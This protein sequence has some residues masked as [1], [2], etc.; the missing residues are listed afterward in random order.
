[1]GITERR[2]RE[3]L[4]R[5]NDILD[6]AEKIF[7]SEGIDKA[8]MDDVA[9]EAEL[10]KGT[11]Y[12]Y[13]KS[14]QEL[15]LGINLRGLEIL[16]T[17]LLKKNIKN[18]SGLKKLSQMALAYKDFADEYP[19]YFKAIIHFEKV[20][21]DAGVEQDLISIAR[22]AGLEVLEITTAAIREGINDNS[23]KVVQDPRV[24]SFLLWGQ[25][26][27]V[28][29]MIS[30]LGHQSKDTIGFDPNILF[31]NFIQMMQNALTNCQAR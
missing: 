14:K 20:E 22:K 3:K 17:S 18:Q 2:E 11:L 26:T 6:A 19:D 13:F 31:D 21:S 24:L 5:H 8:T 4:Q 10:S 1:M 15:Y 30:K 28:I 7:F 23:I 9:A 29:Q 25:T 27:G 12:L 16:K